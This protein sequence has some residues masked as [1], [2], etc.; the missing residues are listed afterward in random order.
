MVKSNAINYA[1]F[2]RKDVGRPMKRSLEN[3]KLEQALYLIPEV[4]KKKEKNLRHFK[5]FIAE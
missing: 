1:L 5:K 4:P 3:V 2:G